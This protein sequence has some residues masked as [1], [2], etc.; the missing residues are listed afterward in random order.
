MSKRAIFAATILAWVLAGS[1]LLVI[2]SALDDNDAMTENVWTITAWLIWG[3]GIFL[4]LLPSVISLVV[5]RIISPA[6][7]VGALVL[8]LAGDN[9]SGSDMLLLAVGFAGALATA[10]I[11][12]TAE[13]ANHN[14]NATAYGNER[15]FLLR[16]PVAFVLPTLLA[17][18]LIIGPVAATIAFIA[19][20]RWVPAV[21]CGIPSLV[22]ATSLPMRI[23]RLA[24]RWLVIVP[25]G[26]VIHDKIVLGETAMFKRF[27][28]IDVALATSESESADASGITWGIPL[29]INLRDADT[30]VF[31]ADKE[32]PRGR[33]IHTLSVLVAPSRPGQFMKTWN[34]R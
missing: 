8:L 30:L 16:P 2:G 25:A 24:T 20:E 9:T 27:A 29:Q 21:L 1:C 23:S 18:L 7:T 34:K 33:A 13:F 31:A 3:G 12:M 15:R 4:L 22:L 26:L 10:L 19:A 28:V 32:H 5:F 17:W 11:A 14:I 6:T